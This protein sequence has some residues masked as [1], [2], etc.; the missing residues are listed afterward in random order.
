MMDTIAN[1]VFILP[2]NP[3]FGHYAAKEKG[4]FMRLVSKQSSVL[5]ALL[6]ACFLIIGMPHAAHADAAP[7]IDPNQCITN[8]QTG[9]TFYAQAQTAAYQGVATN[10]PYLDAKAM[11]CLQTLFNAFNGLSITADPLGIVKALIAQIALALLNQVC[12]DVKQV[13][14][15]AISYVTSLGNLLCVPMPTLP[16]FSLNLGLKNATC[17]GISLMKITPITGVAP[18]PPSNYSL[19]GSQP[20]QTGQ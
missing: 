14:T 5:L 15:Q 16:R 7:T 10:A 11:Y 12:Q 8:A 17:N 18:Y 3:V 19:Y 1:R 20:G 2:A 9:A 13:I 4:R 6:M